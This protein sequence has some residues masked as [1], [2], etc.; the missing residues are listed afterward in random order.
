M[1]ALLAVLFL[2]SP[3][4]AEI[5]AFRPLPVEWRG[6]LSDLRTLRN[7]ANSSPGPNPLRDTLTA[8][9]AALDAKAK[10]APL[11]ADEAADL[12]ECFVRLGQP[13]K[14]VAVLRAAR[15]ADPNRHRLAAELGVAWAAAGDWDRAA[16]AFDDAVSLAPAEWKN[17]D[18]AHRRLAR[19]RAK[20][21]KDADGLDDL[22]GVKFVGESGQPEAGKLAAAERKKL[23]ADAVAVVQRLLVRS[24][25]DA[26]LLWQLGEL[27]NATGDVRTAANILD[28]CVGDFALK[29]KDARARR[30]LYRAAADAREK[31]EDHAA[32]RGT[33]AFKSTRLFAKL[34]DEARLP[35]IDPT[36]V[37]RLPWAALGD[38]TVG[39]KFR[40]T[41]LKHVA[42]LDGKTVELIGFM[43]P[44]AGGAADEFVLTEFPVGCWYCDQ[45]GPLQV[46]V[47]A[48]G[49]DARTEYVPGAVV[50]IGTLE[51][52]HTD[53]ERHLFAVRGARVARPK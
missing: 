18:V 3:A 40:P 36:G 11:P 52:N 41:F 16:S 43:R 22:F 34:T 29:S 12:G 37:N 27:A 45:P 1:R 48:L 10:N 38:T 47:I 44:F 50:V 24:P 49:G 30:T 5:I 46:A 42:D 33:Q 17:V 21:A 7:A 35:K 6:F 53:P 32:N 19:S 51:L 20:E 26:R 9:A 23:P 28:G 13:L 25:A 2:S 31:A 15:R 4:M 14:A 39:R 8:R